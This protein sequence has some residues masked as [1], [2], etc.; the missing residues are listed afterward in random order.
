[1]TGQ[2]GISPAL[3]KRM[4][5]AGDYA[6]VV[7]AVDKNSF[8]ASIDWL[9]ILSMAFLDRFDEAERLAKRHETSCSSDLETTKIRI[10][11]GILSWMKGDA[12]EGLYAMEA[13]IPY[14]NRTSL[15]VLE[16]KIWRASMLADFGDFGSIK[17]LTSLQAEALHRRSDV[18]ASFALTALLIAKHRFSQHIDG[19]ESSAASAIAHPGLRMMALRMAGVPDL[20][21]EAKTTSCPLWPWQ[22]P[23]PWI[24]ANLPNLHAARIATEVSIFPHLS[25]LPKMREM[26]CATCDNRCCYDGVYA[27][28]AEEDAIKKLRKRVPS[29]FQGIPKEFTE[30]G[31]W[32]FLFHGKRTKLRAHEYTKPDYPAHFG[33]TKC[34]LALPNGECAPQRAGA[35]LGYHPWRFKPSICWKF[36]LIGLFN[37]N[38]MEKPHYFG[39]PDPHAYDD[40][41]RGYLSFLP[42]AVVQE[43]GV[44][45]KQVYRHELIHFLRHENTKQ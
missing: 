1:M 39:E 11:S 2:N 20:T 31:E 43:N 35:D 18:L 32:G 28:Q 13:L 16:A 12:S 19:A 30:D 6:A 3:I 26:A 44:S 33:R 37:D 9:Q 14:R 4:F 41:Q 5:Y 10:A 21:L 8:P 42:C 15:W 34:V 25:D 7:D 40:T 29:Y 36:P 23:E 22:M 27:T 17:L 38:A 45:W 24:V